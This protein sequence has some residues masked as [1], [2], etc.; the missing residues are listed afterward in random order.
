VVESSAKIEGRTVVWTFP[1]KDFFTKPGL[2][3]TATYKVPATAP[4]AGTAPAPAAGTAPAVNAPSGPK[5]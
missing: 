3:M 1:T 5:P 2:Q 4:P